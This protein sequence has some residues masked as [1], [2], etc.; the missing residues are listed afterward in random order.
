M[1]KYADY[2]FTTKKTDSGYSWTIRNKEGEALQISE[3][4]L[5]TQA[6]AEIDCQEH[7]QE[8]YR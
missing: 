7:I 5:P 4:D 6:Q 2:Y 1:I 3:E 8:Y